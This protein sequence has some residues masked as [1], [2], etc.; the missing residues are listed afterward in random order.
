VTIVLFDIDGTLIRTGGAGSRAMNRAFEDLF[1]LPG[2]FDGIPMAGRTDKRIV[3][4]AAARAGVTLGTEG[5]QRFRNRY[6]ERLLEALP[7]RGHRN[8]VLPGV[9]SLLEALAARPMGK[10]VF[11]ALLTGNCE[12]GARI[13]LEH[14]DLWRFFP[15]GAYGDD[16]CDRDALFAV[17]IERARVCGAPDVL[18]QD[19]LVVG[20]TELDVACAAAA[21][22][23]SL[24][25]ATG[26]SNADALRQSGADVVFED[27]SDTAAFL[28]LL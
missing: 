17:A 15:C 24:A 9:L 14:F 1:E 18:P 22:A 13:K 27:L 2:A 19:V 26:S 10:D 6:F 3:E 8:R 16:V 5:F 12:Q 4:D 11:V 28:T 7:E 25:V 23:R 21:G 20:D